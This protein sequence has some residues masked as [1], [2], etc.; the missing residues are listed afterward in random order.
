MMPVSAEIPG[1]GSLNAPVVRT[2]QPGGVRNRY[3][4]WNV[5]MP[6]AK[7]DIAKCSNGNPS[8]NGSKARTM[9]SAIS[10]PP[11]HSTSNAAGTSISQPCVLAIDSGRQR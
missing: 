11:F 7:F 5:T 6:R 4:V 10:G 3:P 1:R 9:R 2:F 8:G